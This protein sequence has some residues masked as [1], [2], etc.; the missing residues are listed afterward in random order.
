MVT[1]MNRTL[2]TRREIQHVLRARVNKVQVSIS[3]LER[4]ELQE[5]QGILHEVTNRKVSRADAYSLAVAFTLERIQTGK[6]SPP[7]L[8][9]TFGG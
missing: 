9:E 1:D 3:Q 2:M 4:N 7:E 8:V 5:L 6:V